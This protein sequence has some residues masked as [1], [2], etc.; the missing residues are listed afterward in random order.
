MLRITVGKDEENAA[1]LAAL[2]EYLGAHVA[3]TEEDT[4]YGSG[5]DHGLQRRLRPGDGCGVHTAR[6]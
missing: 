3:A 2:R 6:R 4:G 5:A 1:A